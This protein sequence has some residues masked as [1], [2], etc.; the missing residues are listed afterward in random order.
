MSVV[1]MALLGAGEF[2]PWSEVVDRRALEGDGDGRIVI[3]PTASAPEGVETFDGWAAKGLEHFA[4]LGIAAEALALKTRDDAQDAELA[5]RIRGASAVYFSGGNPYYLSETLKGTAFWRAL[6]QELD[7]GMTYMGCSAGVA[8]LTETTYDA[9]VGDLRTGEVWKPGLGFVRDM[10]FAPH[11]NTV[12]EWFPGATDYIAASVK[13]GQVLVALDEDT[14]MIGD[15]TDWS[16]AGEAAVHVLRD[17]DWE[18]HTARDAF[19]LPFRFE[20]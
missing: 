7:R 12:D 6:L 20:R 11:W 10:L 2:D 16:V 15:G 13:P 8:V 4:D 17:G 1:R 5:E 3:L 14:A 19:T 9:S 18:H